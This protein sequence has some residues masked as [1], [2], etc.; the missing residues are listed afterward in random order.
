MQGHVESAGARGEESGAQVKSQDHE[1]HEQESAGRRQIVPVRGNKEKHTR[2]HGDGAEDGGDQDR[3]VERALDRFFL[4][5]QASSK[6][7]VN[8]P[9]LTRAI[10]RGFNRSRG[11]IPPL[12]TSNV[13]AL[14]TCTDYNTGIWSS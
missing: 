9:R 13:A 12:T 11:Q 5:A 2:A 6:G 3:P 10:S 4:G 7:P 1:Q 8:K 14:K